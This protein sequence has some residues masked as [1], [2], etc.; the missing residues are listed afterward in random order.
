MTEVNEMKYSIFIPKHNCVFFTYRAQFI[1][2]N[3]ELFNIQLKQIWVWKLMQ[4][5]CDDTNYWCKKKRIKSPITYKLYIPSKLINALVHFLSPTLFFSFLMVCVTKNVG[6]V[7]YFH[8]V[9]MQR[10]FVQLPL[11]IKIKNICEDVKL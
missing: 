10:K 3:M 2:L 9:C 4:R 11:Q 5:R 1:L 7:K 6:A 8:L